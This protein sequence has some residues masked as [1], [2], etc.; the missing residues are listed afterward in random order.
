MMIRQ[1]VGKM[2]LSTVKGTRRSRSA[3]SWGLA[4]AANTMN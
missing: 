4:S 3:K 2:E 1:L